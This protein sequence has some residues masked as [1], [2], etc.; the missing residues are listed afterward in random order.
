MGSAQSRLSGQPSQ[1]APLNLLREALPHDTSRLGNLSEVSRK[2]D[3]L[4]LRPCK[5]DRKLPSDLVLMCQNQLELSRPGRTLT[6]GC[7]SP[8]PH[9]HTR[10]HKAASHLEETLLPLMCA[11]TCSDD[12]SGVE[13]ILNSW[14]RAGSSAWAV[15]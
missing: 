5:E 12:E 9:L 7:L 13:R 4:G 6:V 3:L 15:S 10:C 8:A 2:G 11:D 1:I 14:K